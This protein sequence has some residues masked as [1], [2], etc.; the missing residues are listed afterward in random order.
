MKKLST[1]VS[2]MVLLL[3]LTV[4]S[5]CKNKYEEPAITSDSGSTS[6]TEVNTASPTTES[7]TTTAPENDTTTYEIDDNVSDDIIID[8]TLGDAIRKELGY[9]TDAV[10]RI[11]DLE[12]IMYLSVFET[13]I[14]SV[15]G[16]SLLKNLRELR[17]SSGFITDISELSLLE[18]LVYVDISNC[19]ITEIPDFSNCKNLESLYLSNNLIKSIEPLRNITSLKYVNVDTNRITSLSPLSDNK[20]II[21]LILD[22]NCIL[23]YESIKDNK[24]LINA[25]DEGSQGKYSQ[26]IDAE[27]K[28]KEIVAGL[29]TGISELEK[30]KLLYQYIIDH[31]EYDDSNRPMRAFGYDGLLLGKGVCGEYAD[32]FC[33]LANHAGIEAYVCTSDTHAWNIVK[34][35]GKYYHCDTLWDEPE[36]YWRYFNVSPDFILNEPDHI[37]DLQRFPFWK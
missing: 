29:P 28:A 13:P 7:S 35:D 12:Q 26:F 37:Y 16:I 5:S 21:F 18:E 9:D 20:N 32:A 31:M 27:N 25:I 4:I 17:I 34:S 1:C 10:L 14:N 23:D 6:F 30:E 36:D 33:L 19:Y 8:S 22:N 11:A 24:G 15:K 2:M 3:V